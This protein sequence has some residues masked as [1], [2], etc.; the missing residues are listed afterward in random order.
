MVATTRCRD[1]GV[2]D[3]DQAGRG[4]LV[5][6][7][8]H[9]VRVEAA[10]RDEVGARDRLAAQVVVGPGGPSD[11]DGEQ[12]HCADEVAE[13]PF[14]Q[15]LARIGGGRVEWSRS[16]RRVG[17]G[18]GVDGH[19]GF[20]VEVG[21]FAGDTVVRAAC[22][23]RAAGVQHP[24]TGTGT[25]G[26]RHV[27]HRPATRGPG[28]R[29][30]RPGVRAD[31]RRRRLGPGGCRHGRRDCPVRTGPGLL[32]TANVG[33][34]TLRVALAAAGRRVVAA[35]VAG[36]EA[37][38]FAL[39]FSTV[40]TS[41]DAPARVLAYAVGVGVG[42]LLGIVVD[43]RLTGGQSL[44]TAVVDGDGATARAP[45]RVRLAG[46][47]HARLWGAGGGGDHVGCGRRR[48]AGPVHP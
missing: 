37:V 4:L 12:F 48:R 5:Q 32:A 10:R 16:V 27:A 34:W 15:R 44:V 26:D 17:G 25:T 2:V 7:R 33:L 29:G 30:A 9:V 23:T 19:G 21:G 45:A 47:H 41:L 3:L 1:A 40:V 22:S 13:E 35:V 43:E 46:G 36:A 6:P 14:G 18:Q 39:V 20:P 11:V 28:D 42:T 24:P 8:R 38:L 31:D